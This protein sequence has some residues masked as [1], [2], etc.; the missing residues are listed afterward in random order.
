MAKI[1]IIGVGFSPGTFSGGIWC[2]MEYASGLAARGHEVTVASVLPCRN[3]P[4]WF[5]RPVGNIVTSSVASRCEWLAVAA[6]DC[7]GAL[8]RRRKEAFESA[9]GELAFACLAFRPG[10]LPADLQIGVACR[11]LRRVLPPADITLATA[12][13]IALPLRLSGSGRR[14]YFMQHYEPYQFAER[15]DRNLLTAQAEI[16][17]RSGLGLI[18]NSSWL[19]GKV[20]SEFP[21]ADI[22]LCPNAID[23]AVF[24]G[25][26]RQRSS[27]TTTIVISYSGNRI[28][29][30]GFCEMAEAM[31][32]AR[33][34]LRGRTIRW[35]VYGPP[36]I[37][38]PDNPVAEYEWLGFL[39]PP[40][41]AEAYRSADMLLGASWYESFPLFPLEAMACGLPVVTTPLGTEDYAFP[42]ETAEVVAARDPGAIAA[43]LIRLIEDPRYR[44]RIACAGNEISKEFTW[45]KSVSTMEQILLG[46]LRECSPVAVPLGTG[47]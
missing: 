1:N 24:H 46:S 29:W 26:P 41:L 43:G 2:V 27:G 8:L 21:G 38:P 16:S 6:R 42:G 31:K 25:S 28:A 3:R 39:Q 7:A 20:E 23:H 17:Y 14:F 34:A 37:L 4:D 10:V 33:N 44:R 9:L 18:A 19:K 12:S 45:E 22:R 35:L 11:Y 36:A 15:T 32:I 5:P 40:Q 13:W 30:K 47:R